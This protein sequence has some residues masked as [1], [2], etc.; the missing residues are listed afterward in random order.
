LAELLI[1]PILALLVG[2]GWIYG[3]R[4]LGMYSDPAVLAWRRLARL[5]GLDRRRPLGERLGDRLP[6]LRR[7]QAETD[8]GRLLAIAGRDETPTAWLLR[9]AT[10][11]GVVL[12]SWLALDEVI[13]VTQH[14]PGPPPAL[15]LLVAGGVATL[16]YVHLRNQALARQR[17]LGRAIADSLPHLAV[18]T[19]HHR[20]PVSE[21]LLVFARC[22]QDPS[23]YR[24]L[25]EG[26]WHRLVD[27][28]AEPATA[29]LYERIG[30][31]YRIPMFMALG[32]A[33]NMVN[34]RGLNSQQ[35]LS[36][37]ARDTLNDRAA[38]ARVTAAQTKTLIVVPMGLMIIPILVLIGAPIITNLATLFAR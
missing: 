18:M 9:T 19:Y 16:S 6:L 15:G 32:S 38:E 13:L 4:W 11:A 8:V 7:L 30:I 17:H 25:S 34:E 1:L 37:L 22:Q 20:L 23:L 5:R 29:G 21:A 36:R 14:Q 2:A 27:Q 28:Q 31:A 33:L 35:V 10:Y 3:L 26:S 24:F 12:V